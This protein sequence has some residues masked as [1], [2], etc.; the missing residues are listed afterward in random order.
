MDL[1][2]GDPDSVGDDGDHMDTEEVG[3]THTQASSTLP[4]TKQTRLLA[5][6]G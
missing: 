2:L 4:L 1:D 6:T 3:I 5:C